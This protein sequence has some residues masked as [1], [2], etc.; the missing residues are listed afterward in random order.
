MHT[1]KYTLPHAITYWLTHAHAHIHRSTHARIHTHTQYL[2]HN[3]STWRDLYQTKRGEYRVYLWFI[4]YTRTRTRTRTHTHTGF[5]ESP[6]LYNEIKE[7]IRPDRLFP[8]NPEYHNDN[9][10]RLILAEDP[11][12]AVLKGLRVWLFSGFYAPNSHLQN[13]MS[14]RIIFLLITNPVW[15]SEHWVK[16]YVVCHVCPI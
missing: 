15:S 9:C 14:P 6:Y 11:R 10:N 5:S 1:L 13:I 8:D 2:S 12:L 4:R 3:V 16:I 7:A